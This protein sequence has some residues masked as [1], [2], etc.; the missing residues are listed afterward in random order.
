MLS[1]LYTV[2][3]IVFVNVYCLHVLF[4]KYFFQYLQMYYTF[5]IFADFS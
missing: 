4:K 5:Y 1:F 3:T 2:Q